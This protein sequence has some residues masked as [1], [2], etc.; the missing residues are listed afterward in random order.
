ML[1]EV[2]ALEAK[3]KN[4]A[5]QSVPNSEVIEYEFH[6]RFHSESCAIYDGDRLNADLGVEA[7]WSDYGSSVRG[8]EP[9]EIVGNDL[10]DLAD[11]IRHRNAAIFFRKGLMTSADPV[12]PMLAKPSPRAAAGAT[13]AGL[14]LSPR[15]PMVPNSPRPSKSLERSGTFITKR[16]I[17]QQYYKSVAAKKNVDPSDRRSKLIETR[18]NKLEIS[19][20]FK[21]FLVDKGHRVPKFM[22][23]VKID[24]PEVVKSFDTLQEL[25]D[26]SLQGHSVH[27]MRPSASILSTT[28][29][30]VRSGSSRRSSSPVFR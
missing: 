9:V 3:I 21:E 11:E 24:A 17:M 10:K 18:L 8:A 15:S 14:S 12:E 22:S 13:R 19:R 23:G 20:T 30:S 7:D 16:D 25:D 6:G 29:M 2:I 5:E 26:S 1:P 27:S 4:D 28:G